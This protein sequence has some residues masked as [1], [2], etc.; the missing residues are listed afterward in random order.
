MVYTNARG[1]VVPN[2]LLEI[3]A[4]VARLASRPI[5]LSHWRKQIAVWAESQVPPRKVERIL[6][7]GSG[8]YLVQPELPAAAYARLPRGLRPIEEKYAVLAAVH[9]FVAASNGTLIGPHDEPGTIGTDEE[10]TAYAVLKIAAVPNIPPED[11]AILHTWL[12]D[13]AE[14]VELSVNPTG[15]PDKSEGIDGTGAITGQ[16]QIPSV[17]T[18]AA[19][20]SRLKPA[21]R[22][23]Y[24]AFQYAETM[25]ERRLEDREAYEW[26]RENGFDEDKG[27]LG[28]LADYELPNSLE[29][30][31][32]Y[33]GTARQ[34]LG[35]NK[36]TR[37][38]GRRHG[39]S[40]VRS[41]EIEYQ[42]GDGR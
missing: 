29:N 42:K 1:Q 34:K 36:Y 25:N 9:D 35:E 10:T 6:P 30:F 20:L 24:L 23:A 38:G 32:R 26:L 33:V 12:N 28:E 8:E 2:H 4:T 27:G 31:R 14:D 5:V 13:V 21:V 40:I 11:A 16:E 39:G 15:K 37:R 19:I 3:A 17:P 22:K 7:N 18:Q 41:S